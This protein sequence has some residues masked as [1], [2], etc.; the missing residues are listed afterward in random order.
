VFHVKHPSPQRKRA[1]FALI[2]MGVLASLSEI[3]LLRE[4]LFLAGGTELA[5]GVLL[6]AWLVGG[7]AGALAGARWGP[8]GALGLY[9]WICAAV[10]PA[11]ILLLRV[12]RGALS[13][14]SG[15]LPPVF[16]ILMACALA[17]A[18]LPFILGALFPAA[19]G[20]LGR[21]GAARAYILETAGLALG[22][23]L[24]L[25]LGTVRSEHA[26]VAG[27]SALFAAA[28]ALAARRRRI[29]LGA[30]ALVP[31]VLAA[32]GLWGK[33]ER[34]MTA[35]AFGLSRVEAVVSTPGGR[36]V[37][38]RHA[39]ELHVYS[40]GL[41]EAAPAAASESVRLV[42]GASAGARRALVIC[43]DPGPYA[44]VMQAFPGIE[45]TVLA[46]D[47]GMLEF[48]RE[49]RPF[50]EPEGVRV[51][52]R[53]PL[54][55]LAGRGP[56]EDVVMLAAG[57]P[58]TARNNRLFTLAFFRLVRSRLA[59]GGVLAV[60]LPYSP[61][62]VSADRTALA[63][64]IWKTL[65]EVFEGQR[66]ALT[67]YGGS[68]LLL[69][70]PDR[71][72]GDRQIRPP[73]GKVPDAFPPVDYER[74]FGS[75]RTRQAFRALEGGAW[76]LNTVTEPACYQLAVSL[77]QR[78]F[79]PPDVL[80]WVWELRFNHWLLAFGIAGSVFLVLA[81]ARGGRYGAY[82]GALG[83]GFCAMVCQVVVIYLFQSAHGVLYSRIGLIAAA[84]MLGALGGSRLCRDRRVPALALVLL[85]GLS[86][87]AAALPYLLGVFAASG[88]FVS[89][90]IVFPAASAAAGALVGALFPACSNL[91]SEQSGGRVYAADLAGAS[92][93][94]LAAG[95]VL[96]PSLGLHAAALLT[97]F[98]GLFLAFP[99][100]A[101]IIAGK[102]S[103]QGG[104]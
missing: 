79:G 86:V 76:Q 91:V 95:L 69:A 77:S 16:G 94:A 85:G 102:V 50:T 41:S 18:P 89:M 92:G 14:P 29:L 56:A 61:G 37:G 62:H 19:A 45:C 80:K 103:I 58:L 7:A 28:G 49:A 36:I 21:A 47:P 38:A 34:A 31:V 2:A 65:G 23:G 33:A 74:S 22:A 40:G 25:V 59:A 88:R 24:A 51:L 42:L 81:L 6:A 8:R 13:G 52:A 97:A 84:F 12:L 75:Y 30:L 27:V 93:G 17:S 73:A 78:R 98:A 72:F 43:E 15:G 5:A 11:Q 1:A 57:A 54:Q 39:G 10:L 26:A 4:A 99:L 100:L 64:S 104:S 87:F 96:I 101:G 66:V 68:I 35:H 90:Y 67:Q 20:H 3:L 9:L 63:G 44:G 53:E 60:E 48:R 46:P 83:G 70:S 71:G 55:H 82:S 32:A